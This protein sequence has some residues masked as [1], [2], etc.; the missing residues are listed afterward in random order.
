MQRVT[1]RKNITVGGHLEVY[2]NRTVSGRTRAS[3]VLQLQALELACL[4]ILLVLLSTL[5]IKQ[6]SLM[7]EVSELR[8]VA[9]QIRMSQNYW[10]QNVQ[11]VAFISK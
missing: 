10:Q 7:E 2:K 1:G 5:I 3:D 9:E 4:I 6:N 11:K 8:G